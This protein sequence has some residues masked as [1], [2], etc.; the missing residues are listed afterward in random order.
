MEGVCNVYTLFAANAPI[1]RME[2][3]IKNIFFEEDDPNMNHKPKPS[4]ESLPYQTLP[5]SAPQSK[6]VHF[7]N[8]MGQ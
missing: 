6:K 1:I 8:K 3:I 2:Y 7:F 4:F 5:G